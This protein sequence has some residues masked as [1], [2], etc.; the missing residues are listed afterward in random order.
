M[1]KPPPVITIE[2]HP[3]RPRPFVVRIV[4]GEALTEHYL[5]VESHLLAIVSHVVRA[6]MTKAGRVQEGE[7]G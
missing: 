5:E 4:R 6:A 3:D 2:L 7:P 1:S